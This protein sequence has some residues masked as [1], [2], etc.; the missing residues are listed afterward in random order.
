MYR[1][2]VIFECMY[3]F[4]KNVFENFSQ[5]WNI[6]AD[7]QWC[8]RTSFLYDSWETGTTS[9]KNERSR[10]NEQHASSE[11]AQSMQFWY[12]EIKNQSRGV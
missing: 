12:H 8:L 4:R 1:G 9:A 2:S 10:A 3:S 6:I 5:F 7:L 11:P